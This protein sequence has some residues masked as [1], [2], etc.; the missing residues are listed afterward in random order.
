MAIDSA[1]KRKSVEGIAAHPLG[2]SVTPNA[3]PDGQW[4]RQAAWG[5]SGIAVGSTIGLVQTLLLNG[6]FVSHGDGLV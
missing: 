4:R 3:M 6:L 2:P 1:E 5:Y